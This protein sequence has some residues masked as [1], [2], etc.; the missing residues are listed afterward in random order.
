[1]HRCLLTLIAA[2][3]A[4]TLSA[5]SVVVPNANATTLGT[6]QLNSLVRNAGNPRSYQYGINQGELA[7]VPIGSVI[8]GVSARFM[9]FSGNSPS[10]PLTDL[11]WTNYDIF[12]GPANPTASWVADPALNF[13]SA[14][15]AVRTGPMTLDANVFTN[16]AVTGTPNPWAEFY[17]DFQTP[18]LYLGGDLA[19][20]FS[21]GGS[22]SAAIAQ[23]PETVASN[24]SVHGVARSQ[25][26]YPAGTSSTST[27]FY[28]LRVHYGYGAGCPGASGTAPVMVQ[29]GDTTGGLGGTIRL[30]VGNAP[31]AVPVVFALGFTQLSAP[32]GNGCNLLVS[33]DVL[34]LQI[35][36]AN[37]RA[38]QTV[39]VPPGVTASF[40][41]QGGVLDAAAPGGL[42]V[43][44]GVSPSAN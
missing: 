21:H 9:V 3:T 1:M 15:Q 11:T 12:V 7:A 35:S 23:Y 4:S 30:Q 14:P 33:P 28:V 42:T 32:I 38:R 6:G 24:A 31:A 44:N 36:D 37:G 25:N 20:L 41:A 29:N 34:L 10:W 22:T 43:S 18:Y 13:A 8:T 19:M 5:Q 26:F 39:P 40:F 16:L 27:T 2:V 17:F